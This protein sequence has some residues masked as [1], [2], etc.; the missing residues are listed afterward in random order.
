[1]KAEKIE[2]VKEDIKLSDY[3]TIKIILQ[4]KRAFCYNHLRTLYVGFTIRD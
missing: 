4:R 2:V 3:F 1:M